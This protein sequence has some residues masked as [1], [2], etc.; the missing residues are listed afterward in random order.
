ML[1]ALMPVRMGEA[2]T[3]HAVG[4]SIAA[5]GFGGP[6]AVAVFG[7]LAAHLGVDVLGVCL[8]I[9]ALAMY[10]VNRV[11]TIVTARRAT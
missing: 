11:L 8:F 2:G 1:V 6:V 4:A 9:A 3:G 5:A 7:V 10:A